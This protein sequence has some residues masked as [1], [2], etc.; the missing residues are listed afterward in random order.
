MARWHYRCKA[1]FA[2]KLAL[3]NCSVIVAIHTKSYEI[4]F[5][6]LISQYKETPNDIS[7]IIA[8]YRS[9]FQSEGFIGLMAQKRPAKLALDAFGQILEEGD[10]IGLAI[11][12][13]SH[14]LYADLV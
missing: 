8:S 12:M 13:D 2:R 7:F 6:V 3:G 4:N 1:N 11:I 14:T 5:W 10:V 9:A